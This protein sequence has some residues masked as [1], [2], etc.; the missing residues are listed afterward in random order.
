MNRSRCA[1]LVLKTLLLFCFCVFTCPVSL[2]SQSPDQVDKGLSLIRSGDFK[3]AAKWFEKAAKRHPEWAEAWYYAGQAYQFLGEP[4]NAI[5]C[6]KRTLSLNPNHKEAKFALSVAENNDLVEEISALLN[7]EDFEGAA[8][9][10]AEYRK[11]GG[12]LGL[13]QA[14]MRLSF[15]QG[16][17]EFRLFPTLA[18]ELIELEEWDSAREILGFWMAESPESRLSA[19]SYDALICL[20]TGNQQRAD[21]LVKMLL[22][23]ADEP[24]GTFVLNE[25]L[26]G[27]LG[28]EFSNPKPLDQS[29]PRYTNAA[30]NA[31]VEGTMV[32]SGRIDRDG[33]VKDL[34]LVSPDLGYG[35][36]QSAA[37]TITREW[38]FQPAMLNGKPVAVRAQ[39][40]VQFNLRRK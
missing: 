12:D 32:L 16:R 37:R 36:A 38:V 6:Y 26:F 33:K 21:A 20:K 29:V 23:T 5:D 24:N 8:K 40:E 30:L 14:A 35:L 11:G 13:V 3:K 39:I 18:K 28:M 10:I 1:P 4:E 22:A 25:D 15:P 7:S 27:K 17:R 34:K 31:G 2:H 9:W 19:L